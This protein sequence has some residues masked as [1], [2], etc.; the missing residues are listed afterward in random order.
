[1][2]QNEQN[3]MGSF[4]AKSNK[5]HFVFKIADLTKPGFFFRKYIF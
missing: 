1:M 5:P 2:R 4:P 3:R